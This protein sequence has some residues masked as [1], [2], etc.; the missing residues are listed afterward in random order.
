MFGQRILVTRTRQQ[1][2]D[3]RLRLEEL[4]A[5]VLEAPTIQIIEPS[6]AQMQAFSQAI[7]QIDFY[8]AVVFTSANAV[9]AVAD[10]LAELGRDSR[11]LAG[12]HV[13]C[14]GASTA[15][16]LRDRLKINADFV[17]QRSV[18]EAFVDELLAAVDL[19]GKRV[20]LP[21]ADIAR[22]TLPV[23][24]RDAGCAVDEVVAYE[25]KAA[26]ALPAE[27]LEAL[28]AGEVDWV[29]FT[30]SSTANNLVDMLGSEAGLLSR[31]KLASIGPQTSAT[32][33]ACGLA[34][35]VEALQHDVEGLVDAL[36]EM[37]ASQRA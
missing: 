29:T 16:V 3:L 27:V 28:R 24:L 14:I 23:K 30:S 31:C 20:L 26:D 5:E 11:S 34:I 21:R 7:K 32:M 4:G 37:C 13:S 18:A 8:D 15:E 2:S 19:S 25:T 1:A 6:P 22:P 35:A 36:V 10:K 9:H 33:Q 17:P 12:V